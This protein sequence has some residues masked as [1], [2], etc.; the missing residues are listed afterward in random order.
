MTSETEWTYSEMK[1]DEDEQ[2]LFDSQELQKL[3]DE[4]FAKFKAVEDQLKLYQAKYDLLKV[5]ADERMKQRFESF[6]KGK[7]AYIAMLKALNAEIKLCETKFELYNLRY[8]EELENATK[9]LDDIAAEW[10][11]IQSRIAEREEMEK[12]LMERAES[13]NN[14]KMMRAWCN[15]ENQKK[16]RF[17]NENDHVN[18]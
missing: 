11:D 8:P 4:D 7:V 10:K 9:R 13:D 12:H 1:D 2:V 17:E 6:E 3:R 14:E 18:N 5:E 16:V 15:R